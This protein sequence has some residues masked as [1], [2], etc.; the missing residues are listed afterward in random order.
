MVEAFR[1][2]VFNVAA[3]NHDDHTK[4]HAFLMDAEGRWSLAP[5]YDLSYAN[6]PGHP[7]MGQHCMGVDGAFA[8]I[9][10]DRMLRLADR[11]AIPY[12]KRE[13]RRVH[14]V[15][16]AWPEFA[17]LAGVPA[18]QIAAVRTAQQTLGRGLPST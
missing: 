14:E 8:L 10:D 16:D 4:N 13:L 11:F 7:W 17:E 15:V 3:V 1:R 2:M 9:D 12:A 5:A 18:D 6:V